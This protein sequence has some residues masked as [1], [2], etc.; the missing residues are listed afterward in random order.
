MLASLAVGAYATWSMAVRLDAREL[1]LV[2]FRDAVN[3][4]EFRWRGADV[5][6]SFVS[7]PAVLVGELEGELVRSGDGTD[8]SEGDGFALRVDFRGETVLFPFRDPLREGI[9][10]DSPEGQRLEVINDW[11]KILPFVTGA[12]SV[13]EVNEG[14]RSGELETRLVVAARYEPPGL[15]T[16]WAAV[17]RQNWL[18]RMAELDPEGDE[19]IVV[20]TATYQELDALGTPGRRVDVESLPSE[21]ERAERLWQHFVMQQVTPAKFFR[22]KDRN[23]DAALEAMGW[24]WSAALASG[25]GLVTGVL[26]LGFAAKRREIGPGEAFEDGPGGGSSGAS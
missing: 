19:P 2:Y 13:A 9:F 8:V 11:F 26:L 7:D 25:F 6:V 4:E 1:P 15:R 10:P 3:S 24:T 20:T 12:S 21:E 16:T 17:Q 22:A 23:L 5:S 14:L 18:Y